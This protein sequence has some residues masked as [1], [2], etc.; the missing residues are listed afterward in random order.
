MVS[1]I[2]Q[3]V[4]WTDACLAWMGERGVSRIEATAEARARGVDC[5][6]QSGDA[7]LFPQADSWYVGANIPGKARVFMPCVNGLAI[8]RDECDAAAD[9]GYG[10]FAVT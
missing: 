6:N 4:E 2:E 7:T 10:G 1:A 9:G 3:H 5:V 8:Y